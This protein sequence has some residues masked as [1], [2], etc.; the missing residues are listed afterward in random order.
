MSHVSLLDIFTKYYKDLI[1][2]NSIKLISLYNN[3]IPIKITKFISNFDFDYFILFF[4]F[5]SCNNL[6]IFQIIILFFI[7]IM[8]DIQKYRIS[9]INNSFL[10]FH[11]I[12]NYFKDNEIII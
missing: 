10:F 1:S 3:Y 7:E 12:I 6:E 8:Y 9:I 5:L 2:I 4:L 11:T